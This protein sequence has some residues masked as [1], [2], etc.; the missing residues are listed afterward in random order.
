MGDL[1][2]IIAVTGGILL[3]LIPVAGLTA[4]FALK[5]LIESVTRALQARQGT[6]GGGDALV[7][8]ERRLA[9]LEQD[10]SSLRSELHRIGDGKE[11]DR[12]LAAGSSTEAADA[13]S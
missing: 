9:S 13:G 7:A 2:G 12:K 4:R 6:G 3:F 10:V 5:P 8:V 11:F 1:T